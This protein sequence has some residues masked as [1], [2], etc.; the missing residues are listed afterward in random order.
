MA[1]WLLIPNGLVPLCGPAF[2]GHPKWMS[3]INLFLIKCWYWIGIGALAPFASACYADDAAIRPLIDHTNLEWWWRSIIRTVYGPC[4]TMRRVLLCRCRRSRRHRRSIY[5]L[6]STI[7]GDS[8]N[9]MTRINSFLSL[10]ALSLSPLA[11]P[12]QV[13]CGS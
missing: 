12:A 10:R 8:I 11:H 13:R 4:H 9:Y 6:M 5:R 3:H 7:L 2:Y 1:N